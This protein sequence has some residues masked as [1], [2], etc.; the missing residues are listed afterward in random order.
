MKL[1]LEPTASYTFPADIHA[2]AHDEKVLTIHPERAN[3]LVLERSEYPIFQYLE[4]RHTIA[5]AMASFD[6]EPVIRVLTEIEAKGFCNPAT[7]ETSPVSLHEL[8]ISL[9]NA[10]NLRCSHCYMYAGD[11]T[12]EELP[13]SEWKHILTDFSH[14]GF[15]TVTFSGGE[16]LLYPWFAELC[17]SLGYT[18]S[19]LSNGL[20]WTE[21]LIERLDGIIAQL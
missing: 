1:S 14:H 7:R 6:K 9:T 13:L 5:E 16:P 4:Q 3:W 15:D 8:F 17:H 10:C 20:L 21:S 2:I 11:I 18:I 19:V 12:I